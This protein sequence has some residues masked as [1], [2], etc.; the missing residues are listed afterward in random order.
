MGRD[1]TIAM[2]QPTV[3]VILKEVLDILE[4]RICPQWI[5]F[6]TNGRE[7]ADCKLW[8][9]AKHQLA[10]VVG[11]IDGT[12]VKIISP[13][14][15]QKHLYYN[16]KGYYSLNVMIVSENYNFKDSALKLFLLRSV[17]IEC[18]SHT[19]MPG[20]QE[21]V[22]TLSSGMLVASKKL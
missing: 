4:T 6:N 22:T 20:I 12:H 7:V 3:S 16:R 18:E 15:S 1:L 13:A 19:L 14:E 2:A 21:L 11:C 8:F 10:G 17:I 5:K 9:M